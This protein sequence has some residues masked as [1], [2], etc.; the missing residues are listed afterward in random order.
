VVNLYINIF[1]YSIPVTPYYERIVFLQNTF[2][3]LPSKLL[4]VFGL[5]RQLKRALDSFQQV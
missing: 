4:L 2:L 5:T 1:N 3:L